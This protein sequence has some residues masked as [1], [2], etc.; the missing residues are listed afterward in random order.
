[1][2]SNMKRATTSPQHYKKNLRDIELADGVSM[3][4]NEDNIASVGN[5]AK[6]L[7]EDSIM[8]INKSP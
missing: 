4:V 6:T 1:M 7:M 5:S 8:A 2:V 3:V